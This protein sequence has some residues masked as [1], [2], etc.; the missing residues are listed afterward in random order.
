MSENTKFTEEE[1][2]KLSELQQTYSN[3]QNA[4]GQLGVNKI[5]IEQQFQELIPQQKKTNQLLIQIKGLL[6]QERIL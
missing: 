6:L 2:K 5:R 3:V 4:L 1:M